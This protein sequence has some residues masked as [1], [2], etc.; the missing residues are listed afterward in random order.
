MKQRL[1]P[2]SVPGAPQQITKAVTH[3]RLEAAN[4]GKLTALDELAQVYLSLCQ[5]YVTLF[6]TEELPDK[7]HTPVFAT[8]L[9]ERWH[10][11]AIQQA[12]GIAHSWHTNREQAYQDYLDDLLDYHEQEAV[13]TLDEQAK[14]PA[15]REWDV[16]TLHQVCIQ[17]NANVVKLEA[18]QDSS[19]DYWLKISTLERY[20]PL[21]LPVRLAPYHRQALAG[22][23]L[24]SSVQLNRRADGWWLT[25]SYDEVVKVHTEPDAPVIGIDVGI[26]NFVTTSDG[27]HYGTFHGRLRERQKRDRVK[28]RRKAK[29]R[30]CLQKKGVEKLPST[31][32][33]SGQRLIRHVK[34]EINRAVK[35]CFT[36]HPDAQFAYEHLSVATMKYK[37]RAMNAYLRASNLA[38]IPEQIEWNAAK[39][40]VQ[41]TKVKSA[42]T[43]QACSVCY[44]VDKQN[45]PDQHTFC[46]LVCGYQAHADLNAA[47]NIGRRLADEELRACRDRHAIKAVL[48]QRHAAWRKVQGW[49]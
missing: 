5:Q 20:R 15:W 33:T 4:A 36:E 40:G 48:M 8:P 26:A 45:R 42:Y 2:R 14:A 44:Y 9:S 49:P 46:C 3:I 41:A 39:G 29:L 13:G 31:S 37:A 43:S 38:H 24:N 12:A 30:A 22:K 10:R 11:V 19:F 27:K 7:F 25:L 18:S 6:C 23:A 34:Q 28:R 32:S 47:I 35:E 16:P 1:K 21:L 17:A